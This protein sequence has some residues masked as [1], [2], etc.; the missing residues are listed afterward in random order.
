LALVLSIFIKLKEIASNLAPVFILAIIAYKFCRILAQKS[1]L[2]GG[3]RFW[4]EL[5]VF[6]N[7]ACFF[8]VIEGEAKYLLVVS[9]GIYQCIALIEMIRKSKPT[10][11]TDSK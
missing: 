4:D 9:F 11:N 1:R 3:W 2:E 10:K 5:V 7:H 8:I 6:L